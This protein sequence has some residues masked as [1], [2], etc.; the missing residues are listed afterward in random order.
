MRL[1]PSLWAPAYKSAG[2]PGA[3]S[4]RPPVS[5]PSL[6]L[7]AHTATGKTVDKHL[8]EREKKS[9][10]GGREQEKPDVMRRVY[11]SSSSRYV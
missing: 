10:K 2:G 1:I 11:Y 8:T 4:H 5:A 6:L 9:K 7:Y 3:L